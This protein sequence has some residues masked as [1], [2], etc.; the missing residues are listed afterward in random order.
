M[1]INEYKE[2]HNMTNKDLGDLIGIDKSTAGKLLT[3]YSKLSLN[4]YLKIKSIEE[5]KDLDLSNL[6]FADSLQEY[7]NKDNSTNYNPPIKQVEVIINKKEDTVI[8]KEINKEQFKGTLMQ[9]IKISEALDQLKII[10]EDII[11][12]EN[13]LK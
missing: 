5:L 1:T 10:K 4:L 2:K 3:G 8:D 13:I 9:Q 12:L 6:N 7:L 11:N